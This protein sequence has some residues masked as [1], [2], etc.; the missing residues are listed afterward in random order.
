MARF[1]QVLGTLAIV[2]VGVVGAVPGGFSGA[3]PAQ[4][5]SSQPVITEIRVEGNQRIEAETIR[6]YM[7]ISVGDRFSAERVNRALKALFATGLFADVKITRKNSVL[8]VSVI[9]NPIIN[10]IAFEG[11]RRIS[12]EALTAEVQL[13]PRVVY[14]RTKV[15][16]DVARIL[17]IYRRS[18][19]FAATVEP[20]VIQ[21]PQNRVDLAFEI[22][23]GPLTKIKRINFIGNKRFSDSTL[24]DKIATKESRW[25]RFLTT[26][27]T[28]DP[29][30]LTFD[31]ELLRR[32]YLSRGYVDFR[33]ISAVAELTR[34]RSG[35]FITFTVDEGKRYRLG[36]VEIESKLRDLD[37]AALKDKIT[38]VK[39]EWYDA[40]K[41][42]KTIQKL[43]DSIGSQGYAFVDVRPKV[44]RD[45]KNLIVNLTYQIGEGPRVFVERININ[46][47]FR[48]LDEVIRREFRL[49]EGDA[50]NTA[51]LRR[52]EQR[53][54]NLGF[55][56]KVDIKTREG[57]AP[58][59]AIIDVDVSEQSTGE[60][61][62]GVGLS[63]LEGPVADVSMRERNLLG[64]GQ[65]LKLS[66]SISGRRQ[67]VDLSFTEPYFL[68]RE[69]AAGFDVFRR[70]VDVTDQGTFDRDSLG[71]VLRAGYPVT[72][73][74]RHSVRYSARRDKITNVDDS[75]SIFIK[76]Q[77]GSNTT[78]SIGQTISLDK[79]DSTIKP[80]EGYIVQLK[81]DIAGLG[82]NVRYLR[83]VLTGRYYY[84][85][86]PKWIGSVSG[87]VG[88]I[89]GLFGKDVRLNDRFFI[90]GT[91]LRGFNTAGI[92]PRDAATNDALGG[93]TF[94]TASVQLSFPLGFP[95]EFDVTGRTF[96]DA[97]TL[98]GLDETGAGILDEASLRAAG[99]FGISYVSPF[100]PINIDF[101]IPFLKEN[102]DDTE[103]IRF[104][105]G[106]RF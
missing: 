13:R 47:N 100:G 55:F 76:A 21:L 101:A 95:A 34:D 27:D 3:A 64:R 4:A 59:K 99:G 40:Q 78:S 41:V 5:Q 29:D 43:T 77:E 33:V 58:D 24:R 81:Q 54:R 51:K 49:V 87:N 63:S 16:N 82:G 69:V 97:G 56:D 20:K 46:G 19:R 93:N 23:E 53:I 17:S 106:T 50:F 36:D 14:T 57:S 68:D 88:N 1:A 26:D 2:L 48:T 103:T 18:G 83:N 10:R 11:N 8:I 72:D 92:G 61:T 89:V 104:T 85:F 7:T 96:I 45:R 73:T 38:T 66:F 44:D 75:A 90:G 98:T 22:N 65:D 32:F 86:S 67:Q 35:F 30:R 15:Q 25:Y 84:P 52:S 70:K 74:I 37:V 6:S 91:R 62:F 71:F 9:E 105:F 12:D 102:F 31:R 42:E 80:T 94:A 28:Y 39:G 79:R 60:L